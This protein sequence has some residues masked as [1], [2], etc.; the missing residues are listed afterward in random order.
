MR[1]FT[2]ILKKA[3][4]SAVAVLAIAGSVG[5]TVTTVSAKGETI[6]PDYDK[7]RTGSITLYKYV[8]N[9][10]VTVKADGTS[11]SQNTDENLQGVQNA[12]GGYRMLPEKGVQF[13]YFKIADFIQVDT[14]T[15]ANWY[16]TNMKSSYRTLLQ[17]YGITMSTVST[18]RYKVDV[19]TDALSRM[20]K[21][22]NGTKTGE[23]ALRELVKRDGQAFPEVTNYYG[24]TKAENLPVGLYLVAEIDWE[25]QSISKFDTYWART[26]GTQ[27]AGEGAERADIV[28]P[29]SPF[30]V[31]LPIA[32]PDGSGWNYTVSAY[33]KN[34]T[35]TLHKDIVVDDYIDNGKIA[36]TDKMAN[37][38][39]CDYVQ[40]N[41]LNNSGDPGFTEGDDEQTALDG[42]YKGGL[43]HQMDVMIGETV[44]HVISCDLP[45][46]EGEKKITTFTITD[47]MTDGL[48]FSQIRKISYGSGTW[49]AA[50]PTLTA[51]SDYTLSVAADKKSFSVA[52]TAAG[53][54]KINS[55]GSAGYYYVLYDTILTQ[56]ADIGTNTHEYVTE[57]NQT[58][59]ATN[60]NT[61]KLTFSTD[62]TDQ[63]DYYS[64]TTKVFTYEVDLIKTIGTSTGEE[65]D[66][67]Q[68]RIERL[69][70]VGTYTPI[71]FVKTGTD[72]DGTAVYVPSFSG[73]DTVTPGRNGKVRILGLDS[74][75]FRVVEVATSAGL[76]L[77]KN[78]LNFRLVANKVSEGDDEKLEDGSLIHAYAWTGEEPLNLTNLDILNTTYGSKLANGIATFSIQNNSIV[79]MLRTG[80]A[81]YGRYLAVGIALIALGIVLIRAN[82]TEKKKDEEHA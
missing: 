58:V 31:Q 76:N 75:D 43:T 21:A 13:A 60:Q 40:H 30:L 14:N 53:L 71:T 78:P 27:D 38:T 77:L 46:L 56:Q 52:L 49:D 29:S 17:S 47:N 9:D 32:A 7:N 35:L 11:Y 54:N 37:E 5:P 39:P 64:N 72:G 66:D 18:D 3:I 26:D 45:K 22:T 12:T 10:G 51:G 15:T 25:H 63:H 19:V 20:C 67:V 73:Q 57:N 2:G 28:S 81:G 65:Y 24:K 8:N 42:D 48:E 69:P 36:G 33:P 1:K 68:F 59:Q 82:S 55:I 4:M 80:G 70:D 34:G 74:G 50:L 16:I 79:T 61:A 62:R 6:Y 23:T 44:T 41:Y